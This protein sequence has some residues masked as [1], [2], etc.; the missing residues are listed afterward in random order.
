MKMCIQEQGFNVWRSIVDGYKEPTTPPMD[1]DEKK[2]E[3]MIQR[4]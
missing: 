4:I 1:K 3:K 2:L